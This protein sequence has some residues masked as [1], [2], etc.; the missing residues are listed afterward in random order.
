LLGKTLGR[1]TAGPPSRLRATHSSGC[2]LSGRAIPPGWRPAPVLEGLEIWGW[3]SSLDRSCTAHNW[4]VARPKIFRTTIFPPPGNRLS[5]INL[6]PASNRS[7]EFPANCTSQGPRPALQVPG[8]AWAEY[9]IGWRCGPDS[10][11][12]PGS[13]KWWKPQTCQ[14]APGASHLLAI[15]R[16]ARLQSASLLLLSYGPGVALQDCGDRLSLISGV[17]LWLPEQKDIGPARATGSIA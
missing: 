16:P 1:K 10:G 4:K 9:A 6:T 11:R 8:A 14:S 12:R 5:E 15:H 13:K 3:D 7:M 17:E 2:S